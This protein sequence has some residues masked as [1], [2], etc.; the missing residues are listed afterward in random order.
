MTAELP[1][2]LAAALDRALEGRPRQD[3][4]DRA[5]RTSVAYRAGQGSAGVIR[6]ADDAFAY[7]LTRLPATYAAC[8]AVFR[9]SI[10]VRTSVGE[11]PNP[12][13]ARPGAWP[14]PVYWVRRS[15]DSR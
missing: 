5:A 15:S 12:I 3:L 8:Q 7:A 6:G 11:P 4:A 2:A 1:A 14:G 10:L 9:S 13:D